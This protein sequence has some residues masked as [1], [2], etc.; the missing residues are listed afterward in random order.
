MLSR[1]SRLT[2]LTHRQVTHSALS[3]H[4]VSSRHLS[5]CWNCGASHSVE[6]DKKRV[7]LVLFCSEPACGV[8]QELPDVIDF[9]E[10]LDIPEHDREHVSFGIDVNLLEKSFKN[11][12]KRIH[13]DL[14][15]NKSLMEQEL[16]SQ[17]SSLIN[18]AYNTLKNPVKR[19]AYILKYFYNIDA[20]AE[21]SGTYD[22][23][24]VNME[25]FLLRETVDELNYKNTSP[26]NK[27][28]IDEALHEI[29]EKEEQTIAQFQTMCQEQDIHGMTKAAIMMKYISKAKE[30]MKE[31][32]ID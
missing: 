11:L 19:A 2:H 6:G 25:V 17:H 27:K 7:N 15:T 18:Q 12:Q 31:Q 1:L 21:T 32:M 28:I 29:K 8:I 14:Y 23:P 16:S 4:Y 9:Y 13:P 3:W 20:L 30:S 24:A 5:S 10:L 22:D 26:Q